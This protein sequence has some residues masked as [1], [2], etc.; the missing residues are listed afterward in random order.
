MA[1][2]IATP[3]AARS[4]SCGSFASAAQ[5]VGDTQ[6][7]SRHVLRRAEDLPIAEDALGGAEQLQLGP[8]DRRN[9]DYELLLQL[10]DAGGVCALTRH[11]AGLG[12]FAVKRRPARAARNPRNGKAVVVPEKASLTFKPSKVMHRRLNGPTTS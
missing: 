1:S 2:V 4:L 12:A 5:R 8:M 6:E 7:P 10:A 9:G 3:Y 11:G